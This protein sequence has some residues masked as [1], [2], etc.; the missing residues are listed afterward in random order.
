VTVLVVACV[1]AGLFFLTVSAVGIVRFP[2]FYTRA[3]VVATS[4][5]VGILLIIVGLVLHQGLE[6][7]SLRL[8]LVLGFALV[9]NPTAIHAL[10]RAAGRTG[11]DPW[12]RGRS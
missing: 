5:T 10:A 7:T 8:L 11:I 4:E 12:V 1:S 9:G 3:H 6:M 2:D